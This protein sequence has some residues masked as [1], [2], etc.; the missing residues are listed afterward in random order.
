[1][2]GALGFG[3]SESH[4]RGRSWGSNPCARSQNVRC[5]ITISASRLTSFRVQLNGRK[6]QSNVN[7][8]ISCSAS[9]V[10]LPSDDGGSETTTLPQATG[11]GLLASIRAFAF[12]VS[13]FALAIPL[14]ILMCLMSPFVAIFDRK[15]RLAQ[16]I[17]NNIWAKMSSR[18]FYRVEIEGKQNLP[19]MET[20]AV[21]VANHLSALDIFTL[22]HLNRPFKFVSK[23][24]VFFIPIIG[25][26]MFLTGHVMLNRVDSKSQIAVLTTCR[27]L[28]ADGCSVLFFP[29]GTRSKD[30]KLYDFKKGAFSTATK[31]KVAVVPVTI[32][33][34]NHLMPNGQEGRLY[35]YPH[36]VRMVVHPPIFGSN[37][38]ELA[39]QA[40]EAIASAMPPDMVA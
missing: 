10:V 18:L 12:F 31:G 1:M 7:H 39:K 9:A 28:L 5:P 16:H 25:W 34:T 17:V 20:P 40:R 13:T 11:G 30:G 27:D 36:P 23:T 37:A 29:E 4:I 35:P 22:F 33:G 8:V 38:A 2:I 14:F 24:S 6:R 21:Y 3:L 32:L 15:R 19:S 26:S